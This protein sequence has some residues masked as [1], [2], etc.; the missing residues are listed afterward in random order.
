MYFKSTFLFVVAVLT[1]LSWCTNI[2]GLK[3]LRP[4]QDSAPSTRGSVSSSSISATSTPSSAGSSAPSSVGPPPASKSSEV[5]ASTTTIIASS[6]AS[7]SLAISMGPTATM[8]ASTNMTILQGS[9][10]DGTLPITPSITPALSVAGVL[11]ML[12][13]TVYALIGIKNRSIQIFLSVA[14]LTSLSITVLII[15]VV[16]PPVSNAVQGGYLIAAVVPAMILGAGALVFKDLTEGLGCLLG[17]F[18]VSMWILVLKPGG[19]ITSTAW[20]AIFIAIFCLGF[21]G[22]VFS[23]YTR[24][25]GLIGST[26]FAGATAI[27]VGIDCFSRAGLKEFWLF[28]WALNGNLFPLLTVTYPVTRGVRVEIA[29]TIV[30][31]LF[32]VISQLRIWK[33]IRDRRAHQLMEKREEDRQRDVAEE[34]I[35]RRIVAD[36][37]REQARWEAAYGDNLNSNRQHKDSGVGTEDDSV[38]KFSTGQQ[39]LMSPRG[40]Q[41]HIVEMTPLDPSGRPSSTR[42]DNAKGNVTVSVASALGGDE[43]MPYMDRYTSSQD[44]AKRSNGQTSP[45][46]SRPASSDIARYNEDLPLAESNQHEA[47][48]EER[49]TAPLAFERRTSYN[50]NADDASSVATAAS[51]YLPQRR[52]VQRFSGSSLLRKISKRSR[53]H[54]RQKSLYL[55]NCNNASQDDQTSLVSTTKDDKR[56]SDLSRRSRHIRENSIGMSIRPEDVLVPESPASPMESAP[57]SFCEDG[58]RHSLNEAAKRLAEEYVEEVGGLSDN[59][60]S[61]PGED[62]PQPMDHLGQL[63]EVQEETEYNSISRHPSQLSV[64]SAAPQNLKGRLPEATSKVATVYRTN[65]WA[66]HLDRAEKPEADKLSLLKPSKSQESDDPN[67]E[68]APVDIHALQQTATSVP[69][70]L[71]QRSSRESF[72]TPLRS[73]SN[74]SRTFLSEYLASQHPRPRPSPRPSKD[75]LARKNVGSLSRNASQESNLSSRPPGLTNRPLRST[76]TPL[77]ASPIEEG[78]EATFSPRHAS[79]PFASTTLLTQRSTLLRDKHLPPLSTTIPPSPPLLDDNMP[80]SHRRSLLLSSLHQNNQPT[81]Q[82]PSPS[83]SSRRASML[84]A[85]RH[86]VQHDLASAGAPALETEMRRAALLSEKHREEMLRQEAL[87]RRGEREAA[88]EVGMRR[89]EMLEAH[90]EGMRRMQ[91]GVKGEGGGG[92]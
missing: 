8:P 54:S 80:L 13:G 18:C 77:V 2:N 33:V 11:L 50:S 34:E 88:W 66:K 44:H 65:E 64:P 28:L 36:N 12:S 29:A 10:G 57:D 41:S 51:S 53:R 81:Y 3:D 83:P 62:V 59:G 38:R 24:S 39:D 90:R 73:P 42:H 67:E 49:E 56:N 74:I 40:S 43:D 35:G 47:L 16:N 76:S 92:W 52:S 5:T 1:T 21:F 86:A 26:S 75:T 84:A 25:Y 55:E 70:S 78:V 17:G 30:L 72:S 45:N 63:S 82:T 19:T 61:S 31:A 27:V 69:A 91:R 15:Y 37:E 71:T 22:L 58:T 48:N 85:W 4:R 87:L 20:K 23:R 14:Y 7:S 6:G 68:V 60:T 9:D 89:G 32:G 46:N 79:F